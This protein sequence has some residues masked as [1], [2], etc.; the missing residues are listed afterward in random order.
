MKGITSILGFIGL[1]LSMFLVGI[2]V[3]LNNIGL[4]YS[5]ILLII[6]L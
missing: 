6:I 5:V 3:N 4:I 1:I 2:D